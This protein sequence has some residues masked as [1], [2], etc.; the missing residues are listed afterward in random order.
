M[1]VELN[2]VFYGHLQFV[3]N[4]DPI[5]LTFLRLLSNHAKQTITYHCLN[6]TAWFRQGSVNYEHS[7]RLKADN[8]IEIHAKGTRKYKP[9][10]VLDECQVR[11]R[12]LLWALHLTL[13]RESLVYFVSFIIVKDYLV[14]PIL[15]APSAGKANQI[16]YCDWL[17]EWADGALLTALDHPLCLANFPQK[18]NNEFFI[19]Q[20]CSVKMAGL[21]SVDKHL[22][23][24]L[25]Q[26]PAMLTS[27]YILWYSKKWMDVK[28]FNLF[29]FTFPKICQFLKLQ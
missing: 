11:R 15:I 13:T 6:S 18:S 23:K 3:Y 9:T 4:C 24:E 14:L 5:Q 19:A 26:Y 21:A 2:C 28:N 17:P 12:F 10:V 8:G 7:I 27:P 20:V 16:F 29:L 25:G 22:K 1:S